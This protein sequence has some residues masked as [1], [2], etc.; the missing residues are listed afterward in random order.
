MKHILL[1]SFILV[2]SPLC[3]QIQIIGGVEIEIE[4]APW[5]A[6]MWI[7]NTAG[8][9][10]FNRSGIIVSENLILTAAHD[11]PDYEY[12]HLEVQ[13]GSASGYTGSY[14]KVYRILAHP[15]MDLILL[16]LSESLKFDSNI[17]PIDYRSCVDESIYAPGTDAVIYGWGRDIPDVPSQ[18]LKLRAAHVTIISREE[19][20]LIYGAPIAFGNT[21]VSAGDTAIRM[22]GKGDSGGP[23]VVRDSWQHNVLAGVAIYA[24]TRAISENSGL[25][26]Y[27]EV[28]PVIEWIDSLR[29]E[30]TGDDMV[31]SLGASFT[32]VNM[33]PDVL[34]VEWD[35]SGLTEVSSTDDCFDAVPSDI[36]EETT[37]YISAAIT[38]PL[39]TVTL[40]KELTI[41]PRIDIDI[42][43][44]YNEATAKYEMTAKAVN[45]TAVD[46]IDLLKCKDVADNI[47]LMG[48]VWTCDKDMA[49]GHSAIFDIN[50]YPPVT[51]TVSVSK[52][53]CDLT[54]RL[55]KTFIIQHQNNEFITVYN[56]PGTITVGGVFLPLDIDA[57]EQLQVTY[58]KDDGENSVL[59]NTSDVTVESLPKKNII[60]AGKCKVSLFSRTGNILVSEYFDSSK[61][62]LHIDTSAFPPDIYILHIHNP[63]TGNAMSRTLIVN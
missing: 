47:K 41:M 46:D 31:S 32:I 61:G 38:T 16:Q 19:A 3:S 56:E 60:N 48:F 53:D 43:I 17:S 59:L 36:E 52:Y 37:G 12:D 23:L 8:V 5:M 18:S 21:I 29:C 20:A 14:Y 42:S 25:T 10:L 35:Y 58:I 30:I 45:L 63:N 54:V 7:V 51:H 39:G 28:K 57:S 34:S 44:R 11:M 2:F 27:S 33:P 50:P 15:N 62:A 22:G 4:N 6:S 26:V 49:L 1:I 40:Y 13:V 9:R 55:E 24:D